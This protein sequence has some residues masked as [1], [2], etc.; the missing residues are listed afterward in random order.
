MCRAILTLYL[1]GLLLWTDW[2]RAQRPPEESN[3][4][5]LQSA[6]LEQRY[7]MLRLFGHY[8]ENGKMTFQGLQRLLVNLGLGTV[9]VVEIQHEELGHNHVSHLDILDLQDKGHVHSHYI[10]DHHMAKPTITPTLSH[11][12]GQ[13]PKRK[14]GLPALRR[15]DAWGNHRP[16]SSAQQSVRATKSPPTSAKDTIFNHSNYNHWHGNCLNMSQLLVNFG[17]SSVNEITLQQ[18]T[19]ICPALLYQIDSRVCIYHQDWLQVEQKDDLSASVWLCGFAAITA[20]SLTSLMAVAVIPFLGRSVC[21]KLLTFLVALAVGTLAA[22]SLLHL[23]PH[24]LEHRHKTES[25][26]EHSLLEGKDAVWKGLAVLGGIYLLFLIENL[27]GLFRNCGRTNKSTAKRRQEAM[28]GIKAEDCTKIELSSLKLDHGEML[29]VTQHAEARDGED[30][31]RKEMEV[32][33]ERTEGR[34]CQH[35]HGSGDTQSTGAA[36]ITWMVI[37]G[38]GVHNFTDGLAIGTAFSTGIPGGLSTTIAV[39]CHELPHEL[40]DFALLMQAGMEV[41]QAVIFNLLSAVFSYLGM[42]LGIVV[43][44]YTINVTSWVFTITA[45]IFLYVALVDMLPELLRGRSHAGQEGIVGQFIGET[46]G[47]LL[48]VAVM[49]CIALFED[50]LQ[51]LIF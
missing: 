39:F 25:S 34:S 6:V 49:L 50:Q 3:E 42:M 30:G 16:V 35:S 36:N 28:G 15:G 18:F 8:G 47:F 33:Q 20:I 48:G 5:L 13:R 44:Q 19:Y 37:L 10:Q 51:F 17:L 46:L 22:D 7:Y 40:G 26:T 1:A 4:T 29:K 9:Q 11:R 45:G 2:C 31:E 27:I 41:R 23:M 21:E 32:T 14:R 24:A 12:S 43:G 38:D